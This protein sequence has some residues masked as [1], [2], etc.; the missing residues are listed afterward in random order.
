MFEVCVRGAIAKQPQDHVPLRGSTEDINQRARQAYI[1]T[2]KI[3]DPRTG[4]VLPRS[5]GKRFG[6]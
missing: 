1:T 6:I 5:E 2:G 4:H 3:I